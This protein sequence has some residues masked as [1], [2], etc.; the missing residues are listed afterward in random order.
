MLQM[1]FIIWN[2]IFIFFQNWCKKKSVQKENIWQVK[3][4]QKLKSFYSN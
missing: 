1:V 3:A 2:N 4:E